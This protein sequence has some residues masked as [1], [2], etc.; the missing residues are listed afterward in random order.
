MYNLFKQIASGR[1]IM[2]GNGDNIKSMAYVENLAAFIQHSLSFGPGVHLFNY[3][4]KPDFTMNE[5]VLLVK[6]SLGYSEKISFRLP[7]ILAY[8]IGI[9]FDLISLITKKKIP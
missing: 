4:D 3:T 6:K 7:Y 9:I 1:F 5:L 8:T 2:I